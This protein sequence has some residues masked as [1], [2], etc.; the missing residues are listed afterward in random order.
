[1]IPRNLLK[2]QPDRYKLLRTR[3]RLRRHQRLRQRAS[4]G[5]RSK[6][7]YVR[8]GRVGS[9]ECWKVR[10]KLETCRGVEDTGKVSRLAPVQDSLLNVR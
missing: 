3:R 4:R 9:I 2:T 7:A 8:C 5:V 6:C 10:Q 1:M